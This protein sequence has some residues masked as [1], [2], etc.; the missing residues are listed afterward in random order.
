[1]ITPR[2][3]VRHELIGLR[4]RVHE[5]TDPGLVGVEGIVLDETQK[6]L[7]IGEPGCWKKRVPKATCIFDFT[8]PT[9]EVVR[10]DG[11]VILAR[12]EERIKMRLP[13]K[14]DTL[15][16]LGGKKKTR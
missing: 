11:R 3:L 13:R 12:P 4:A 1:M 6:T 10:V 7:V 5:S 2:N 8:L 16:P 14:W 9:G 15:P